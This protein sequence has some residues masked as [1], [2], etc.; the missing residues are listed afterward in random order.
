VPQTWKIHSSEFL[1][2]ERTFS[3]GKH[4]LTAISNDTNPVWIK[5]YGVRIQYSDNLVM[6]VVPDVASNRMRDESD[7]VLE[8]K[9]RRR[10]R[11]S[12]RKGES[13]THEWI[14]AQLNIDANKLKPNNAKGGP[15]YVLWC[16]EKVMGKRTKNKTIEE[17]QRPAAAKWRRE[18]HRT[19]SDKEVT[20]RKEDINPHMQVISLE[21]TWK[22][23]SRPTCQ[24]STWNEHN[25]TDTQLHRWPW[26]KST[27]I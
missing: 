18:A 1:M 4:W 3:R 15:F 12:K 23:S 5:I 22:N 2:C 25:I 21:E 11:R 17:W 7:T 19:G 9:R 24:K 27:D 26:Y 14:K 10:R 16:E 13:M 6:T 8:R 20:N